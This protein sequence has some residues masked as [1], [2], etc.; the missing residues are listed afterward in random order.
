LFWHQ[1]VGQPGVIAAIAPG[2]HESGANE[3]NVRAAHMECESRAR[4]PAP[5]RNRMATITRRHPSLTASLSREQPRHL[6]GLTNDGGL[7]QDEACD[8]IR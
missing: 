3:V 6:R 1:D 4:V 2:A 7:S 8:C 5:P